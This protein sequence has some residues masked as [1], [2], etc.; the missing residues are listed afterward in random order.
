MSDYDKL[1]LIQDIAFQLFLDKGYEATSVRTICKCAGIEAPTLY[2]YFQSKKGLFFSIAY[3]FFDSYKL[4]SSHLTALFAS[5]RAEEK[6][7]L[8]FIHSI[9]FAMDNLAETR[10]FF[11]YSLFPPAELKDEISLFLREARHKKEVFISGCLKECIE[12][13]L[14]KRDMEEASQIYNKF[15]SS[16]AFDVVFSYWMPTDDQLKN[17][18][19]IFFNYHLNGKLV[20]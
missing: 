17:L 15:I 5:A 8:F 7:F 11:R 18:W 10:F 2:Y 9:K 16:N 20:F 12:Q 14:I 4:A 1:K 3:K 6:L 13:G 19:D